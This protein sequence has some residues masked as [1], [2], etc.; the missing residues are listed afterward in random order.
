MKRTGGVAFVHMAALALGGQ[1][2]A[3]LA[4]TLGTGEG[5]GLPWWRVAGSLIACLIVA[6]LAA[7]AMKLSLQRNG[8]TNAKSAKGRSTL[9]DFRAVLSAS[10]RRVKVI[11]AVRVS[12]SLEVCLFTADQTEYLVAATAGGAVLLRS[13]PVADGQGQS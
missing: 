3:A 2:T 7:I 11:E 6:A 4:Q 9:F 5:L 12:Q 13:G 1:P 10:P 8:V